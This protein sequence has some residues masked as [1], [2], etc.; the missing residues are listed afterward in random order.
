MVQGAAY[1][2]GNADLSLLSVFALFLATL[3]IRPHGL[4]GQQTQER[5]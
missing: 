4:F 1:F 2:Y 5:L 3:L